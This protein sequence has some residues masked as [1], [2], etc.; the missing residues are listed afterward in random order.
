MTPR[1]WL[2]SST[3]SHRAWKIS[4]ET[5]NARFTGR[6]SLRKRVLPRQVKIPTDSFKC[7]LTV[8]SHAHE[9][10]RDPRL[11]AHPHARLYQDISQAFGRREGQERLGP[12]RGPRAAAGG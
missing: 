11:R 3:F 12:R 2:G 4:S 7:R 9:T 10:T 6:A 8:S 1:V 5:R